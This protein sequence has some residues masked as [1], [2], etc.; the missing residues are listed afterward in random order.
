MYDCAFPAE[1]YFEVSGDEVV[2]AFEAIARN[3]NQ[4]KLT[5]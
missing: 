2:V 1:Y 4:L 5:Q 3:I